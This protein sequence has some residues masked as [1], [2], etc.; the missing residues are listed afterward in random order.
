MKNFPF[1]PYRN[2]LVQSIIEQDPYIDVGGRT[3]LR[4]NIN[5]DQ[6]GRIFQDRSHVFLIRP[7]TASISTSDRIFNLNVRGKRGNIVQTYPAVEYD[8]HPNTLNIRPTDL[9]HIQWT[10]KVLNDF[11]RKLYFHNDV[12]SVHFFQFDSLYEIMLVYKYC[13]VDIS[14]IVDH[15]CLNIHSIDST[16]IVSVNDCS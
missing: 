15:H 6:T 11:D 16:T 5:T 2:P 14:G 7:R 9:V 1:F 13:F 4:M 8:F 3:A 10:G 12:S